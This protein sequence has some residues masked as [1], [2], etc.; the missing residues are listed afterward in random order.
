MEKQMK[1]MERKVD[2]MQCLGS[3]SWKSHTFSFDLASFPH[4]VTC[5]PGPT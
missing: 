4:L 2:S 3:A 1:Q 5:A